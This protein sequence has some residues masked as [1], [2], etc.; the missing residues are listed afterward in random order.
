LASAADDE[1]EDA[2][3]APACGFCAAAGG[4]I[5]V[6]LAFGLAAAIMPED[7][8]G[9]RPDWK[10]IWGKEKGTGYM[11]CEIGED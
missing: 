9:F 5:G 8:L 4:G 10:S 6:G 3:E 11:R 7:F 1:E 2:L